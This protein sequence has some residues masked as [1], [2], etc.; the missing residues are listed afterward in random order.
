M[1]T[2]ER[3]KELAI[4]DPESG[5]FICAKNRRGSKNKKETPN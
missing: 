2:Q 3:L 1:I 5:L 4:Y